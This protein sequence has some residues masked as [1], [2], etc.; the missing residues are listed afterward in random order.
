ME[1]LGLIHY[2]YG[3]G[4]GKTTAAM[5]LALRALGRGMPVAVVQ[6]LKNG[7]SGEMLALKKFP[8]TTLLAVENLKGFVRS[9]T[10]EQ[11]RECAA[12]MEKNLCL[13]EDLCREGKCQM[14][15]LDE[16]ES[17][18]HA[19]MIDREQLLR[20]LDD[21]PSGVEIVLTGHHSD[22]D[23]IDRADYVTHMIKEKHPYDRGI[24]ARDGVER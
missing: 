24:T 3:D 6:F 2:Y 13:A 4:K 21:R 19:G 10:F 22:Q 20:F 18:L 9:M 16:I 12:V 1:Q 15:I 8:Q 17:A 5:G 11:R 7:T 23:L 14:L